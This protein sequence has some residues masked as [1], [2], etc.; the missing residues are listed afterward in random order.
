MSTEY[1]VTNSWMWFIKTQQPLW[2][3]HYYHYIINKR[4]PKGRN[5]QLSVSSLKLHRFNSKLLPIFSNRK[6]LSWLGIVLHKTMKKEVRNTVLCTYYE[7]NWQQSKIIF[8]DLQTRH[9]NFTKAKEVI[10]QQRMSRQLNHCKL[11]CAIPY[12]QSP[13]SSQYC[14]A[15]IVAIQV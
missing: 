11:V 10:I 2:F 15:E 6:K 1:A 7:C 8:I 3:Q 13:L 14:N 5:R 4:W 12:K 9:S